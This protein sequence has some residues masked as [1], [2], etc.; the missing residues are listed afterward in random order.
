MPR[1]IVPPDN[2]RPK[3]TPELS[4]DLDP[5]KRE[6][7][8]LRQQSAMLRTEC[9]QLFRQRPDRAMVKALLAE[10]ER[11]VRAGEEAVERQRSIIKEL[12]RAGYDDKEARSVLHALLNTQALHV[13]TRDRLVELLTE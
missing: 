11:S 1:K 10:A 9:K 13:L 6:N 8:R 12:E 3:S 5:A 2:W 4:H 7:F